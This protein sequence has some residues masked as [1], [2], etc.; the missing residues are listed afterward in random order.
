MKAYQEKLSFVLLFSIILFVNGFAFFNG[1]EI[2]ERKFDV[3]SGGT[4]HVETDRGSI[5][6]TSSNKEEVEVRILVD[7]KGS[8]KEEFLED[9][10]VEFD[11]IGNNVKVEGILDS[12]WSRKWNNIHIGYIILVPEEYNVELVT[13]GG[14]ISVE[15]IKGYSDVHTSGGS[16]NLSNVIGDIEGKTSGGS[17]SVR[18]V[19]GEVEVKT[20]GGGI[21]IDKIEGDIVAKTSGGSIRINNASGEV[22][23]KT[24]GGGIDVNEISGSINASTS[25]GSVKASFVGQPKN[26]CSLKTSGGSVKIY[27]DQDVRVNIDASTS[28]GKITSDFEFTNVTRLKKDRVQGEINGGGIELYLKTSA[29][30]IYISHR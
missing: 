8:D 26:D 14:G 28:A 21:E 1:E 7:L 6:V 20:S 16:V 29:G 11:K 5:E 17:I 2:I 25:G 30:N 19:Q 10:N 12:H 4:L 22:Y 18:E 3:K 15:N 13:S 9:F 27:M 24:S 23:A